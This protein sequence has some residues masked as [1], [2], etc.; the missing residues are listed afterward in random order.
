MRVARA[1]RREAPS[2]ERDARREKVENASAC[3]HETEV[4]ET[5]VT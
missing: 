3:R 2:V 5:V 1:A 4:V